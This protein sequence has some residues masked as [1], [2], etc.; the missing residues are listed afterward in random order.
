MGDLRFPAAA[1]GAR[2]HHHWS[3]DGGRR[4]PGAWSASQV[5]H[6]VT[7]VTTDDE[8]TP[9]GLA[10]NAFSSISLDPPMVLVCVQRSSATHPALHRGSHLGISILAADQLDVEGLRL[11]G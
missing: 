4:R 6:G 5:H 9:K 11:Q 2:D 10:V 7:V 8:G 3:S 1:G